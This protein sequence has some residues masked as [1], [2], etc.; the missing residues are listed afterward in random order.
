MLYKWHS[1]KKPEK[2]LLVEITVLPNNRFKYQVVGPGNW[3]S[4]YGDMENYSDCSGF[5][6]KS[7]CFSPCLEPNDILKEML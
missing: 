7:N 5:L 2:Y 3:P 4:L 6:E 1:N